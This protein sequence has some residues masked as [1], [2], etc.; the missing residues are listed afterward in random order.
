MT[1]HRTTT[2]SRLWRRTTK[3]LGKLWAGML[4]LPEDP[5]RAANEELWTDFPRFPPF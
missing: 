2:T 5:R 3:A 4:T 1:Q